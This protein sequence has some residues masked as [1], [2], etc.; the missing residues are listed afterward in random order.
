MKDIHQVCDKQEVENKY[1]ICAWKHTDLC[2]F[3]LQN[4]NTI[5]RKIQKRCAIRKLWKKLWWQIIWLKL[6]NE[7][8]IR[9]YGKK[10]LNKVILIG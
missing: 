2:D 7:P 4:Q 3:T 10:C 1:A 8:N 5:W 9:I 6:S